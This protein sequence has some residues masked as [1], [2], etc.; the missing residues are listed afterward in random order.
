MVPSR[1]S[2]PWSSAATSLEGA[3]PSRRFH[4]DVRPRQFSRSSR[5]GGSEPHAFSSGAISPLDGDDGSRGQA[6]QRWARREGSRHG[7]GIRAQIFRM[8]PRVGISWGFCCTLHPCEGPAVPPHVS[9]KLLCARSV[10]R[11]G[12]C[13]PPLAL[14]RLGLAM[15]EACRSIIRVW[16][17]ILRLVQCLG[18]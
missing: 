9:K 5:K 1:K 7:S 11:I 17:W 16:T 4:A 2:S 10:I 8:E 14:S 13:W 15:L 18:Q 12:K 3:C 6:R